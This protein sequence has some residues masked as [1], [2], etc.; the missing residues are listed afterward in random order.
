MLK[1]CGKCKTE[2]ALEEFPPRESAVDGRRNECR[3]C[4]RARAS[5][6][7]QKNRA[8]GIFN[9]KRYTLKRRYGMTQQDWD[10]MLISQQGRCA[11][12]DSQMLRKKE[13]HIDHDHETN[14]VRGMLCF[15]CNT[16]LGA[17]GD[18]AAGL[19]RALAYVEAGA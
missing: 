12:C 10:D 1:R 8:R 4:N 16:G 17:L 6:W 13:P 19:R 11:L 18:N 7:Y 14:R 15:T 2:K 9:A 5:A 3:A